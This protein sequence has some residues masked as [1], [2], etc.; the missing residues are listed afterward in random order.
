MG[1]FS[2]TG[3]SLCLSRAHRTRPRQELQRK[4]VCKGGNRYGTAGIAGNAGDHQGVPRC[5]GPGRR[6]PDGPSR[7]CSRP[8]GGERRG[9]VHSDE[10]PL[11]HLFQGQRHHHPGG[12]GGQLQKFQGGHGERRGHGAPGAEPGSDPY[13]YRQPVAGPLSQGGRH[14]GQ[15]EHHAQAHQGDL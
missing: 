3:W 2:M 7:D 9:Q 1:S 8:D 13:R 4:F 10:M 14:H 11:R 5:Q 6:V 12:Q 15:R